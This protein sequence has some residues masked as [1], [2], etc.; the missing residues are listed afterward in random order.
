M[1]VLVRLLVRLAP[2]RRLLGLVVL[3]HGL[4]SRLGCTAGDGGEVGDIDH[5]NL[6]VGDDATLLVWHREDGGREGGGGNES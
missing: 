3:L 5:V 2:P 4:R 6:G 1:L